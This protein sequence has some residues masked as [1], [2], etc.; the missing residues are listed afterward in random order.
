MSP[1]G[2]SSKAK[3]F[4][5]DHAVD[6]TDGKTVDRV[7]KGRSGEDDEVEG[8]MFVFSLVDG[9]TT[10]FIS[11]SPIFEKVSGYQMNYDFITQEMYGKMVESLKLEPEEDFFNKEMPKN[12]EKMGEFLYEYTTMMEECIGG[13]IPAAIY[14]LQVHF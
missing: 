8:M 9:E 14:A 13:E 2:N 3:A 10:S 7:I 5:T 12:A 6:S 11:Y 1:Q 4:K